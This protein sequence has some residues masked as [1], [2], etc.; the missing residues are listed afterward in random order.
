M[1][2]VL[3]LFKQRTL[4]PALAWPAY[5]LLVAAIAAFAIA[6]SLHCFRMPSPGAASV[7]IER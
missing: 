7:R 1:Q 6:T 4:W 3:A 2:D 5:L